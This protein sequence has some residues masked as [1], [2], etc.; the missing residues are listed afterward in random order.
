MISEM[1]SMKV[2]SV[3]PGRTLLLASLMISSITDLFL[4]VSLHMMLPMVKGDRP[5]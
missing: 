5:F 4:K 3:L 1:H 2:V